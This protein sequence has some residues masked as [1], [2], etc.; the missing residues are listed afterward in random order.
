M[1]ICSYIRFYILLSI[2]HVHFGLNF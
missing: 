2:Y 1:L